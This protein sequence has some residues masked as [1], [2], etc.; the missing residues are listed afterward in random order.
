MSS[1]PTLV[2]LRR[3]LRVSDN[4]ALVEAAARGPVVPLFVWAPE[5]EAPWAPGAASR[6]WLHESLHA[7]RGELAALGAP[8]IIRAGDSLTALIAVARESGAGA[9]FWNRCYD[10]SRVER[11]RPS[12]SGRD[13]RTATVEGPSRGSWKRNQ[14]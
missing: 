12:P 4:P 2:W 6:V 8:M 7:L 1:T 11:E 13:P 14:R 5:E 9:V 3:D 10:P